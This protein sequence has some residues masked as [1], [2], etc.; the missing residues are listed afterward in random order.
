MPSFRASLKII[1]LRPGNAPEA[2]M[3]TAVAALGSMHLVEANQLD[4]VAGVPRITLRFTVEASQDDV[5]NR[6]ARDA[7]ASMRH[8]V[9]SVALTEGLH[10][11]R[12]RQGKWIPVA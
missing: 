10:V 9:E 5:E 7:G 6:Q 1:G 12:R 8:A 4:I 11:L 2:V 3:S